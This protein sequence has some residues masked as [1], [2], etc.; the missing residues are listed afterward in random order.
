[1]QLVV[2]CGI[3]IQQCLVVDYCRLNLGWT[4]LA[5]NLCDNEEKR[6][7]NTSYQYREE[8]DAECQR[9]NLERLLSPE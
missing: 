2:A 6:H 4:A 7:L 8:A 1:M 9:L 5:L 3:G